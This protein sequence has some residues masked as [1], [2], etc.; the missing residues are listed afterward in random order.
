MAERGYSMLMAACRKMLAG[1]A[2]MAAGLVAGAAGA[3]AIV[4]TGE[5]FI[6]ARLVAGVPAADGGR[7]AGLDLTLADGWK[8]Y[9][10]SPGGSGVAPVFD[11]S[12]SRNLA[13]AEVLWPAPE[14]FESFGMRTVGYAGAVTLPVRL[15]PKDPTRPIGLRLKAS[16]GVCQDL[17][18]LEEVDIAEEI[19]PDEEQAPRRVARALDAVPDGPAES[20]LL[21]ASCRITGAGEKRHF[22]ARLRFAEPLVAPVVLVEAPA[23][24]WIGETET[25]ADGG[26]LTISAPVELLEADAW[27]ERDQLRLTVLDG[28]FAADIP[29][30]AAPG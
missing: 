29:G 13:R 30:C 9:W 14:L 22:E 15:E 19:R 24:V 25:V 20:G 1:A 11:W 7:V 2:L 12:G 27:I 5:S 26:D 21:A 4:S 8:T 23:S 18:V 10:R 28:G 16:L 6:D 3:Q 17:C